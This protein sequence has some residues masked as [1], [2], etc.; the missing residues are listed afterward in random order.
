MADEPRLVVANG[1]P[2][3]FRVREVDVILDSDLAAA[4][5]LETKRLNERI[6]RNADL[7]DDRHCFHLSPEEFAALRSQIATSSA[8]WGGRRHPP[9][10]F[11]Q[12]GVARVTTFVATPEALRTA[13]LI[14][15]TFLFVQQQAA[16]GRRQVTIEQPS[17][18]RLGDDIADES[19]KLRK[20][21]LAALDR[22]LDTVID[23]R[24]QKTVAETARDLTAG[25]LEHLRERLRE[26]G[27]ENLK[28]EAETRRVLAEAEKIAADVRRT[29]AEAEGI[30]LDNLTKR[31]AMVRQLIDLQR[32]LEPGRLVQLLDHFETDA[33]VQLDTDRTQASRRPPAPR[34]EDD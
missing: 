32:E 25:A 28:L 10:V 11:T 9:R 1:R 22:L 34:R 24:T 26:K 16:T 19:R 30:R 27:L 3:I 21:L 5:G 13:D 14:I 4:L 17:R 31:I 33:P 20:K 29:D 12:R 2:R 15:D 23:I 18:Y 8:E 7:V 6:A